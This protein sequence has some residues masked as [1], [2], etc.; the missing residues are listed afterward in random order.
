MKHVLV[1]KEPYGMHLHHVVLLFKS[2][3]AVTLLAVHYAAAIE[4]VREP[5]D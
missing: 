3:S 2:Y 1:V 4:T 5:V